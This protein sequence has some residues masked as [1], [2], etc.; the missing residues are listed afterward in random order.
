[1]YKM[2]VKITKTVDLKDVPFEFDA[3]VGDCAIR[4]SEICS[5]IDHVRMDEGSKTDPVKLI[6]DI[7]ERLVLIDA[8]LEDA[9]GMLEGYKKIVNGANNEVSGNPSE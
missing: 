2:R 6:N 3:I 1:M 7:R 4:A 5:D 8:N 9:L